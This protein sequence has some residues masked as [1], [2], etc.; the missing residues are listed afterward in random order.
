MSMHT[1]KGLGFRVVFVV[2]LEESFFPHPE[3]DLDEQRRLCYVAM[4]RAKE[5]LYMCYSTNIAGPV[6][7]GFYVYRPSPFL[8]EIPEDCAVV[9]QNQ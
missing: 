3:Q 9:I 5:H 4:T 6:A 7:Q 1:S 8:I 2:G